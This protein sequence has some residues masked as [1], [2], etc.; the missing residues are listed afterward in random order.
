MLCSLTPLSP[1]YN[2][3]TSNGNDIRSRLA[4]MITVAL[5]VVVVVVAASGF[6]VETELILTKGLSVMIS[7]PLRLCCSLIEI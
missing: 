2:T 7:S 6:S 3:V 4:A 1:S 5:V